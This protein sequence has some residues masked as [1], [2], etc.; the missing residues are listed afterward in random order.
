MLQGLIFQKESRR[1]VEF[2]RTTENGSEEKRCLSIMPYPCPFCTLPPERIIEQ[3]PLA[4]VIHDGFPVSP[5][6]TL[7]I[8][9]RHVGSDFPGLMIGHKCPTMGAMKGNEFIR[10]V[11]ALGKRRGVPAVLNASRGKGSHVMLYYGS[12]RTTVR[13]PKDELKTGTY[14]A[15]LDQPGITDKDWYESEAE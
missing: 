4:L 13:N 14:H 5:G 15:M 6:H 2:C 11:K 9:R 3:T 1:I 8:P 10:K 12:R 7:I